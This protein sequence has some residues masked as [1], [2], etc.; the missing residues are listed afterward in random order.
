MEII[1]GYLEKCMV[2]IRIY[3]QHNIFHKFMSIYICDISRVILLIIYEIG[4][5]IN[6]V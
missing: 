2:E 4:Y 3:I 5:N 1:I 6:N